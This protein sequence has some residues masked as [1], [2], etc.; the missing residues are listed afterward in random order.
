MREQHFLASVLA[1]LV[2]VSSG[3]TARA[4]PAEPAD[5][6]ASATDMAPDDQVNTDAGSDE[7][8][9]SI[10]E[11]GN[12]TLRYVSPD[13]DTYIGEM[14]DGLMNG[15]GIFSFTDRR[16]Y[17]GEFRAGKMHGLGVFTYPDGRRYAGEF[18]D[19][20]RNGQ[21]TLVW[22]SN[23]TYT[24]AWRD[25]QRHGRGFQ[26]WPDGAT[27]QGDFRDGTRYGQGTYKYAD[28]RIVA[29]QW[30][31]DELDEQAATEATKTEEAEVP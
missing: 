26:T 11:L 4:D 3:Y 15:L 14:R 2:L 20:K 5:G 24:G 19:N 6:G 27:Y 23:E 30:T 28:G 13:G 1:W 29:G 25:N 9:P 10:A 22:P 7:A 31:D 18:V 12:D 17:V 16:Q 21:G 8:L